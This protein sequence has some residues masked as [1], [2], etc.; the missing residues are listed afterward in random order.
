MVFVWGDGSGLCLGGWKW[1]LGG[2]EVVFVG[3]GSG[4]LGE[5]EVVFVGG[6]E[7]GMEWKWSLF[8]GNGSGLCLGEMICLGKW[9]WSLL[10]EWKWSLLG[11]GMEVVFVGGSG[12][13]G[14]CWGKM[15]V[16]F[17]GEIF[18]DW[19]GGVT[20]KHDVKTSIVFCKMILHEADLPSERSH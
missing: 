9:K 20:H 12:G 7:G 5:M 6:G 18:S 15:G 17:V 3:N 13:S 2:M 1:S 14:L 11:G 10:G 16:V 19:G 8:G 4:L